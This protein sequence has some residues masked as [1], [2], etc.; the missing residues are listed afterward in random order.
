MS[1]SR[2]IVSGIGQ[3]VSVKYPETFTCHDRD[4]DNAFPVTVKFLQEMNPGYGGSVPV[5]DT[6]W[7]TPCKLVIKDT[8]RAG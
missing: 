1:E 6:P 2:N 8:G 7:D 5:Y 4:R 3:R